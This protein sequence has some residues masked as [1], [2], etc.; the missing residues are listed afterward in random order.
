[1]DGVVPL[2]DHVLILHALHLLL[3][4]CSKTL[5]PVLVPHMTDDHTAL[6]MFAS[7]VGGLFF[8]MRR[9]GLSTC[10]SRIVNV[11]PEKSG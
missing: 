4:C 5:V 11:S 7:V 8:R 10:H 3:D 6:V 2:H 9:L 1:M